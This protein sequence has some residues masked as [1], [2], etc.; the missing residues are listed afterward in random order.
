MI[1]PKFQSISVEFDNFIGNLFSRFFFYLVALITFIG[2]GV[3][4]ALDARDMFSKLC[5]V[6]LTAF[7]GFQALVNM[8]GITRA[9]P[10]TGITLPFVSYGGFSLIT[11]FIM[12]GMLMAFS[13]RNALDRAIEAQV[14]Q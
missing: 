9:L 11:S 5:S 2:S 7:I 8:G 12:L 4:T 14:G 1:F 6:G 10:M 13:H 3:R